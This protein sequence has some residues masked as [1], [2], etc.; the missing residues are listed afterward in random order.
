MDK[1]HNRARTLTQTRVISVKAE[2][3]VSAVKAIGRQMLVDVTRQIDLMRRR[4]KEKWNE[5]ANAGKV[6]RGKGVFKCQVCV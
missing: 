3:G 1:M 4:R 6:E 5:R 2:W